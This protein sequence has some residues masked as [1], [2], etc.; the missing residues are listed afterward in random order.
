MVDDGHRR[1]AVDG[2]SPQRTAAGFVG[3]RNP[4]PVG[5]EERSARSLGAGDRRR[6]EAVEPPEKE[7]RTVTLDPYVRNCAPV[8]RDRQVRIPADEHGKGLGSGQIEAHHV[9][10]GAVGR[11]VPRGG[12]QERSRKDTESGPRESVHSSLSTHLGT[13]S[14]DRRLRSTLGDPLQFRG[15]VVRALPAFFRILREARPDDAL[16]RRRRQRLNLRDRLRLAFEDR[17]DE[18]RATP[19][20]ERTLARHHLVENDSERE[21]VGA[22]VRFFS[23]E[24]LG[25]HVL[26][27]PENRPFL[28]EG[29]V[30]GRFV[31]V[32]QRVFGG[33]RVPRETEVE[34][35][36]AG[37]GEHHVR[38]LEVA[39]NHVLA[40]SAVECGSDLDAVAEHLFGGQRAAADAIR[41][42]LAFEQFHDEV[43]D[44]VLASD[45]EETA[46][47]RVRE[48]RDR[49]RLALET[50]PSSFVEREMRRKDLDRDGAIEACVDRAVDF[51]HAAGADR[52][53]DLVPPEAASRSNLHVCGAL[54]R[55]WDGLY[56]A[57]AGFP[58]S[59]GMFVSVR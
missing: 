45:V 13:G 50:L 10:F 1:A 20:G 26:H 9:M 31:G 52:R 29:P 16:E 56:T 19:P 25:G 39:V 40:V 57:A 32:H 35:L 23:F 51:A 38:R 5:G 34:Q 30:R 6:A 42:R 11:E 55:G 27:G 2:Y 46:D 58:M 3:E 28:R 21:D 14:G 43:V 15:D 36:C 44:V 4:P 37:F 47:V 41:E 53:N 22:R 59:A 17:G 12:R 33:E 18:A 49:S 7:L 48:R 54:C 24:L 8:G